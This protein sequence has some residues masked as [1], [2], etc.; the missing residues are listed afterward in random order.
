MKSMCPEHEVPY[1]VCVMI[2]GARW[3]NSCFAVE[4]SRIVCHSMSCYA[5]LSYWIGYKFHLSESS[6]ITHLLTIHIQY[7]NHPTNNMDNQTIWCAL[8][9][10]ERPCQ[11]VAAPWFVSPSFTPIGNPP[12]PPPRWSLHVSSI[13]WSDP[14]YDSWHR[15]TQLLLCS[16]AIKLDQSRL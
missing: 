4:Q 12:S 16:G 15:M 2:V 8:D 9:N 13:K 7:D 3:H 1:V 5:S 10:D 11:V 14:C 6:I